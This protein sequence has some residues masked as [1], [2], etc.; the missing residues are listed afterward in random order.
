[1]CEQI[2]GMD[3]CELQQPLSLHDHII[4]IAATFMA[5][6]ALHCIYS[7]S[8]VEHLE[9][10]SITFSYRKEQ[11]WPLSMFVMYSGRRWLGL[12]VYMLINYLS[13]LK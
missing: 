1:M 6:L 4:H 11:F 10:S 8:S 13:E 9:S 2:L 7:G 3:V 12:V 5:R